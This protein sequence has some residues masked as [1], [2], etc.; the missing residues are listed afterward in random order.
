M[1][2]EHKTPDG[3]KLSQAEKIA[4]YKMDTFCNILRKITEVEAILI[5]YCALILFIHHIIH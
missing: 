5:L 3:S 4:P 1:N 2:I